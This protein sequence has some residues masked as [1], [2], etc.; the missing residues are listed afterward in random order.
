MKQRG[1]KF[2]LYL[3]IAALILILAVIWIF[4]KKAEAQGT[5]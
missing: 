3:S 4:H 5:V 2:W 1:K